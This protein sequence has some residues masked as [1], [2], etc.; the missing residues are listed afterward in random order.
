MCKRGHGMA[1]QCISD[2]EDFSVAAALAGYA[3]QFNKPVSFII[4]TGML[5]GNWAIQ[6]Y[7]VGNIAIGL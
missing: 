6:P 5:R 7:Y 2:T 1:I 3:W 4:I